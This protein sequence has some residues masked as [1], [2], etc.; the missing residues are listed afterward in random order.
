[1]FII[2]GGWGTKTTERCSLSNGSITCLEQAPTLVNYGYYTE[3]FLVPE[4]FCKELLICWNDG[5]INFKDGQY[6]DPMLCYEI[7]FLYDHWAKYLAAKVRHT[8]VIDFDI[9]LYLQ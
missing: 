5:T 4:M 6:V 7:Q 3:V 8:P 9:I 2:A 1:M